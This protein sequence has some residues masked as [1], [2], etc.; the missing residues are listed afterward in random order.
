MVVEGEVGNVR[1]VVA[2]RKRRRSRMGVLSCSPSD[3]MSSVPSFLLVTQ[4]DVLREERQDGEQ[5]RECSSRLDVVQQLVAIVVLVVV[6]ITCFRRGSGLRVNLDGTVDDDV[7][8][9]VLVEVEGVACDETARL[10][11]TSEFVKDLW[12]DQRVSL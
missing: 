2:S 10:K 11:M 12:R 5:T 9:L 8:G 1:V 3:P 6:R 7:E 4:L